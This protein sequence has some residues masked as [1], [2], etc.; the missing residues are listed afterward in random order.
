MAGSRNNIGSILRQKFIRRDA[1][2]PEAAVRK[3]RKML[4][5]FQLSP[6]FSPVELFEVVTTSKEQNLVKTEA[7]RI[8]LKLKKLCVIFEFQA[9]E[10]GN[11]E[12]FSRL[13]FGDPSRLEVKDSK[14]RT[15]AHQAAARNNVNILHFIKSHGGGNFILL[16]KEDTKLHLFNYIIFF[17]GFVLFYLIHL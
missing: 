11:L 4:L 17:T 5:G 3:W 13:F 7:H 12:D 14:G 8:S 16:S 10:S 1:V 6:K 2:R 9:A 15:A